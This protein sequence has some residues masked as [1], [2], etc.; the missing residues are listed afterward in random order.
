MSYDKHSSDPNNKAKV[1]GIALTVLIH[2]CLVVGSFNGGMKYI[3]P[4]PEEQGILI[5]FIE[6][7]PVPI[8][9]NTGNP[10]RAKDAQPEEEVR[11]VQ[12]S[13]APL[14]GEGQNKGTET[15]IGPEGDVEVPE[16]PRPKP[17]NRKALFSSNNNTTDTTAAQKGETPA[18]KL[19]AG[20]TDG[21]TRIGTKEGTPQANLKGRSIEGYLPPPSFNV[22]ASGQVVVAIK[23]DQYGTV[24][25]AIAGAKGTTV[26]NATLWKAAQKAALKAKFNTSSSAPIIQEGTITYIF[27]LK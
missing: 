4:P 21:N 5:E 13:E 6:E 2:G 23:V 20:H 9:V 17:I 3:Y 11:L 12:K 10:P 27:T 19:K 16:P 1:I 25:S 8:A 22:E 18:D 15:S 26:Q 14:E 24:T 7:E